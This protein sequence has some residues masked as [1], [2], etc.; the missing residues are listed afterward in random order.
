MTFYYLKTKHQNNLLITTK[1][2]ERKNSYEIK[3]RKTG[4]KKV[5]LKES[6]FKIR[7]I[8]NLF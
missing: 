6:I 8:S 3:D 5:I 2:I 4:K 1:L 7:R